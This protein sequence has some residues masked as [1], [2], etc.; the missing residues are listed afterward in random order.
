MKITLG[1]FQNCSFAMKKNCI[2]YCNLQEHWVTGLAFP[3]GVIFLVIIFFC[4]HPIEENWGQAYGQW[5]HHGY[6][7]ASKSYTV[8][9]CSTSYSPWFGGKFGTQKSPCWDKNLAWDK[10][11]W[12]FL[13]I[14]FICWSPV[15]DEV[16]SQQND[17]G[18][19]G[20]ILMCMKFCVR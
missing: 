16:R 17:F 20:C 5:H 13:C 4:V 1:F 7:R 15:S 10:C 9:P 3:T 14:V 8:D 2:G 11:S 6:C 12:K 19:M 18:D